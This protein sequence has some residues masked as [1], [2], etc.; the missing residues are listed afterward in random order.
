MEKGVKD[1]SAVTAMVR[2]TAVAWVQSLP[3]EL[4]YAIG[5]LKKR[6]KKNSISAIIVTMPEKF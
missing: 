4:L 3:Q 2:V 5:V 1:S 6:K